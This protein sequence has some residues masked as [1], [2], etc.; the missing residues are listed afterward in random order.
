M[1]ASAKIHG[2]P[3]PSPSGDLAARA[4]E[5]TQLIGFMEQFAKARILIVGDVMLDEYLIGDADRISPEAPVPV[6]RIEG[7]KRLVGGA[8]N[9]ARN[10]TALG[11]RAV[12]VGVRG[13]DA[14][15]QIMREC[16]TQERITHSLLSLKNRPTTTKT[17]ILA[18]QQ[19]VLRFDKEDVG[20]F[21]AE[22]TAS[23]LKL[24]AEHLAECDAL[25]LSDYG[26]GLVSQSMVEGL[27]SLLQKSGRS[28]PVLVDP[29][30]QNIQLYKGVSLLTPNAK[31]T[32][33]ATLLPVKTPQDIVLA[34]QSLIKR[35]GC[36]H[37]V[38]TLGS[39][40][41]AVFEDSG[42]VWHIPT[43]ARQVFDVT[44]AG[45]TVIAT[46][47]MGLATGLS[48]VPACLLA[49]YAAGIVVAQV[50]AAT[51]T[52]K[53]LAEALASLPQPDIARWL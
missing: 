3:A 43:A 15:G 41:M 4:Y 21:S 47:A 25:I 38:T 40:G 37:L 13:D 29:K 49:N 16:L 53:Q 28:I 27:H 51:T 7:E 23:L 35:L 6:V 36:A 39:R 34:G 50:G 32:S 30:P 24:T 52:P 33:E 44:G 31:E 1:S 12:L 22:E 42:T 18:R 9:V 5:P 8:G 19:Q 10:V 17:R 2:T 11:G 26:K 14:T 46:I 45:D 48:L 20:P